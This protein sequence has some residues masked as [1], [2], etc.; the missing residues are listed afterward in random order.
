MVLKPIDTT[1]YKIYIKNP[2]LDDS[3]KKQFQ[4]N[5]WVPYDCFLWMVNDSNEDDC[6][7][8]WHGSKTTPMSLLI[9]GTLRYLGQGWTFKCVEENTGISAEVHRNFF[10]VFIDNWSTNHFKIYVVMPQTSDQA[11]IH[12][13]EFDAAGCAGCVCSTDA[14]HVPVDKC[15]F[16]FAN[17]NQSAK[18]KTPSRTF[19][20]SC[21]HR[22]YILAT[23]EGL[24]A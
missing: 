22:C 2:V 8:R 11:H 15:S 23:T 10:H 16:R 4:N 9:L 5:F 13:A 6:Y 14:T 3:F 20:L 12:R 18:L 17:A 7:S 21:N 19:D 1:W 24:P